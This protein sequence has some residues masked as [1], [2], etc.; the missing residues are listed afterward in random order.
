VGPPDQEKAPK[1]ALTH[2]GARRHEG[3]VQK[4]RGESGQICSPGQAKPWPVWVW[5]GREWVHV[6]VK[7]KTYP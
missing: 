2:R 3:H 1:C 5:S 4:L 6:T 7:P